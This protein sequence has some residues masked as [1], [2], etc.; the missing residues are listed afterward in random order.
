MTRLREVFDRLW[1]ADDGADMVQCEGKWVRWGEVR[2][3]AERIDRVLSDAGC[4]AGGRVA[5]VLGNRMESVGALIAIFRA[6]R[7]LVTISPLQPPERMSE[8]LTATGASWVLA[9]GQCWSQPAF[10]EGVAKLG[11]AGW[12]VDGDAVVARSESRREPAVGDPAVAI[13]MLTS[14]TTGRPKRIPLT[15][16]QLEASLAAP[17]RHNERPE[18]RDKPPFTG[19]VALVAIPIVHIG[20]LFALLQ[21]LVAARRFVLLE[22]FT[23]EGW[24]AAVRE[25]KPILAGLPP[26]AI[27]SVLDSDIPREDLASVRAIN[28]GTSP[29]DPALV[30]AF[31]ERYGIPILIVYGATEFCGAVAGWTVRDFRERWHAKKG[32][33]GRAF[34]GVALRA[35]DDDGAVLAP[36]RSGRLQVASVQV[37]GSAERWVTTSDLAHIDE[38]G[39]LYIDGRA[40]DVILRGGFK[41]AP[42]R[43]ATALRGHDAV[44]DAAVDGMPDERLGRVPVAAVQLRSGASA[45]P[46]ELRAHCRSVLTPYEVP[47]RVYIVDE[48]PRGA[49]LKVDRRRLRALLD[50]LGGSP[51]SSYAGNQ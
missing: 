4:G 35:V 16:R 5:V 51:A 48:L 8:D 13:E 30:D 21:S 19:A 6:E 14:G 17:L 20:G 45:T 9:P 26:P 12:S 27:R 43:V 10:V 40:D 37:G 18:V 7:T 25:H 33:V 49:A 28:A 34:P 47:A 36:G 44:A 50:Q 2:Q 24:H 15:R 46:E 23:L 29:V 41:V 22:R 1:A 3:L 32:S 42:D 31:Y 39:F 11:A 38:D